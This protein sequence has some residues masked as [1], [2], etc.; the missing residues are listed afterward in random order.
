MSI[1]RSLGIRPA[2]AGALRALRE[3]SEGPWPGSGGGFPHVRSELGLKCARAPVSGAR[4]VYPGRPATPPVTSL[5]F[6]PPIALR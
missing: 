3:D 4:A 6:V 2:S 1:N 5:S